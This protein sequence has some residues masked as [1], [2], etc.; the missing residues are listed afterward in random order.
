MKRFVI[1]MIFVVAALLF[2]SGCAQNDT[3]QAESTAPTG[4]VPG[5]KSSG[6]SGI[7]P[8]PGMGPGA[9]IGW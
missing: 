1:Q 4:T 5:E 3:G 8:A 2:V 7:Q 6:D 9:K